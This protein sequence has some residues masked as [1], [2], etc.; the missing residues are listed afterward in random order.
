MLMPISNVVR[1]AQDVTP[2]RPEASSDRNARSICSALD[3]AIWAVCSR[4]PDGRKSL[5]VTDT[6]RPTRPARS[7]PK[8]GTRVP[9]QPSRGQIAPGARLL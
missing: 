2:A 9:G 1:A 5:V 8:G 6:Q 7:L 3:L 4:Y